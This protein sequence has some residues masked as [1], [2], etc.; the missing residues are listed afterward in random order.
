MIQRSHLVS[1]LLPS[2]PQ[3]CQLTPQ[4]S[5]CQC[6]M[7]KSTA[8]EVLAQPYQGHTDLSQE[9]ELELTDSKASALNAVPVSQLFSCFPV[10]WN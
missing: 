6:H 4:W 3:V 1:D 9:P 7:V 2:V 5:L 10:V 8:W